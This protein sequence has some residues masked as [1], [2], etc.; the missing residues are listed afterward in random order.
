MS[1]VS[2]E[3]QTVE[4]PVE[5][6]KVDCVNTSTTTEQ[7]PPQAAPA[8]ESAAH[9]HS[10]APRPESPHAIFDDNAIGFEDIILPR[11][12]IVQKVGEL[13]NVFQA[14]EVVLDQ[15]HVLY[16]PA[17]PA[18][19]GQP[20]VQAPKPLNLVVIGFKRTSFIEKIEGGAMGL[21]CR[22]RDEVVRVGGT[23]DYKEWAESVKAN[24]EDKNVKVLRRFDYMTTALVLIEKPEKFEDP[25]KVIFPYEADGKYYVMAFFTMK[26][27]AYNAGAKAIFTRKKTRLIANPTASYADEFFTLATELKKFPTGN[28]AA[29]PDIR[30]SA[31]V[32]AGLVKLIGQIKGI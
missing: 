19:P 18:V 22:S 1:K 5:G 15:T 3:K 31:P 11:I 27:S 30:A 24:K 9:N 32:T 2:F 20:A 29:V 23:L 28:Y 12:N 13:S 26:S 7:A 14:G 4:T 8:T 16:S 10:L 25:N 6:V 17:K 21:T